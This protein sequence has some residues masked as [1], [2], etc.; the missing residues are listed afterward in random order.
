MQYPRDAEGEFRN[1]CFERRAIL[2]D[3]LVIATH[4][5]DRRFQLAAARILVGFARTD[6]RL[7]ADDTQATDFLDPQLAVGN[8]PVAGNQ[9]CRDRAG[10]GDAD[11]VGKQVMIALGIGLVSHVLRIGRDDNLIFFAFCHDVWVAAWVV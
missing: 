6:E 1:L 5:T 2:S 11:G 9:L 10:V 7:L 4:G 8:E 3:H